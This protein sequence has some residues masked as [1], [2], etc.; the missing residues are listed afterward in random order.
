MLE[1]NY[2][3]GSFCIEV[4]PAPGALVIFGASG[5][6]ARRKLFPALFHL[7]RRGM[8]HEESRIV[9]CARTV[10]SDDGFRDHIRTELA[11]E[12]AVIDA[13]LSHV[14]YVAGD[15]GDPGFSA[16]TGADRTPTDANRIGRKYKY[17]IS[18]FAGKR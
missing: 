13:F 5:D 10:Y 8:L 18:A 16:D 12:P 7:F 11:G 9:G 15:Y 2:W 1:N 6:L 3:R 17:R 14:H 4:S